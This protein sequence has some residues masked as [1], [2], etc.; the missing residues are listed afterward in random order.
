[1]IPANTLRVF[2][3]GRALSGSTLGEGGY[4]G[5]SANGNTAWLNTV[6]A[7][8]Q[9]GAFAPTPNDFGPWGGSIAFDT[10]HTNWFFGSTT[11]GLANNQSDFLTVA[12]H[13]MGHLL[14]FGTAPSFQRLIGSGSF[15]GPIAK[16]HYDLGLNITLSPDQG[17]WAEGT[18]DGGVETSMDPSVTNGTR[19]SYTEVDF[20]A[21]ADIGWTVT[22]HVPVLDTSGSPSF[23]SIGP[24]FS[25]NNGLTVTALL[26]SGASITD[27]DPFAMRGIAVTGVDNTQ[28]AAWQYSTASVPSWTA[29]GSV[30]NSTARLLVADANTRIR[31]VPG[32][33]YS[34][35]S[36]IS[37]RAWDQT[38]GNNTTLA[39]I[40]G[41]GGTTAFSSA[42]DTAAITVVG[43][44]GTPEMDVSGNNVAIADDDTTPQTGD[45]TDFGSVTANSV[46]VSRTFT[47]A[48]SGTAP[49]TLS[50]T[51]RVQITGANASD[52]TVSVQ[53]SS[54]V[55]AGST[56]TFQVTFSPTATGVRSATI[57]IA[58]DDGNENPY[59]FSIQGTGTTAPAFE[60]I[61][62]DGATVGYF[63]TGTWNTTNDASGYQ[64][65]A[66]YAAAGT[67]STTAVYTF[68]SLTAGDY[69][70]FAHWVP[71]SN[72]ATTRLTRSLTAPRCAVPSP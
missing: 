56:T 67:G 58:N 35:I 43:V 2:V 59:N 41:S 6:A 49:L 40:S 45:N 12:I 69:Q 18:V 22:D 63:Q 9:T 24:N 8:G 16:A 60:Q 39:N 4:G 33:G 57:S 65:N 61:I 55:T 23:G 70:V 46:S 28:G 29:F 31:F 71:F 53:P 72:R 68:A 30:T 11:S 47:I 54:S 26:A 44:P 27:A 38:S 51:P 48:N 66:R 10:S 50:G 13:E 21:L 25:N 42:V 52:F 5:Y 17:H 7:R 64:G 3:G 37:F 34:G 1:M 20:G 19:K 62:D 15:M 36:S 14:G 32:A